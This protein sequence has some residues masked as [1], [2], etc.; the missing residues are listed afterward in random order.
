VLVISFLYIEWGTI[1][2]RERETERQRDKREGAE[3]ESLSLIVAG[4][5]RRPPTPKAAHAQEPS[6]QKREAK[7]NKTKQTIHTE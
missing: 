6:K 2:E 7:Q 5:P 1:K 3:S 4:N